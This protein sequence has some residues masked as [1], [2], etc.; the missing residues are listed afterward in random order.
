M[1]KSFRKT[2]LIYKFKRIWKQDSPNLS[3]NDCGGV[4]SF[5]I[6]GP[7]APP[8]KRGSEKLNGTRVLGLA[9]G[10]RLELDCGFRCRQLEQ[11]P[12]S[13][14]SEFYVKHASQAKSA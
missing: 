2:E 4:C 14:L 7:A 8:V 11:C 13:V 6:R 12:V 10:I 5:S 9:G 1:F 3:N